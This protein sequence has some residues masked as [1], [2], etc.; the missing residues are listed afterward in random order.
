MTQ[1]PLRFF[2]QPVQPSR[3]VNVDEFLP[4]IGRWAMLG[5][6]ILIGSVG[7]A[8]ALAAVIPYNIT[9][10]AAATVRPDGDV[11]LVQAGIDGTIEAIEV[12]PNQTVQQGDVIAQLDRS[13]LET[14]R[15]QLVASVRQYQLQLAQ[16]DAQ[17][18]SLDT[19]IAAESRSGQQAVAA[20][21]AEL[22]R[23]QR[24]L[25]E[26]QATTLA[27]L[28]EAEAALQFARSEWQRY[29]Q[30][31]NTGAVSQ[32]Q[33]EE[34]QAAVQTAEAQVARAQAA[35]N[36]TDATVAIAQERI[37]QEQAN[38]TATVANLTQER[39]SLVQL[40]AD[41]QNQ[42]LQAETQLKQTDDQLQRS[43]IRATT[44][45]TILRLNLRNPNQVVNAGETIAEIAPT[46]N[47]LVLKARVAPQD[48]NNI[49]VGQSTI[50]RISACPY[51]DYGTLQGTVIA[52][53][54]DAIATQSTASS[55]SAPTDNYFEVTIQPNATALIRGNRQCLLQAGMEAQSNIIARQET[56]LRFILRRARI[57]T[58]L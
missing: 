19:Q 46:N 16:M 17:I 7:V 45:G 38:R 55:S 50:S 2:D 15:D 25:S 53:S 6:L 10:R 52:V 36:P 28:A 43:A 32:L 56:P 39:E 51:P 5:G 4:P 57:L 12:T 13:Q 8:I 26:Q 24:A 14:Q 58:D 21:Q 22:R 9:V 41:L 44:D 23:D 3:P 30:L 42:L 37:A 18:R 27:D 47:Q 35:L 29:Q 20:A 49:Q 11:R 54:P 48:I 33:V 34:K 1:K 40:R 31:A